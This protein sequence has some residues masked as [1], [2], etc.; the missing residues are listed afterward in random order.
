[1][2]VYLQTKHRELI[3]LSIKRRLPIVLGRREAA[4]DGALV[5]FG[6]RPRDTYMAAGVQV[7]RILK[8]TAP[9]DL[10]VQLPTIFETIVNLK[11]AKAMGISIPTSILLRADEVIE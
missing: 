1:M 9:A 5:S 3:D 8:G 11:T 7:G 10:P 2:D 6:S 4:V